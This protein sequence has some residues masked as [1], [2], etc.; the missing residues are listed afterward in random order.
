MNTKSLIQRLEN[1]YHGIRAANPDTY[2]ETLAEY[3]ERQGISRDDIWEH[4]PSA[5]R[6]AGWP[7]PDWR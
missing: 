4:R 2:D 1:T 7:E 5:A 3:L 6:A